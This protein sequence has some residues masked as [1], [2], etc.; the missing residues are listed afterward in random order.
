MPGLD[1]GDILMGFVDLAPVVLFLVAAIYLQ[2]DLYNKMSKGAFAVFAT[3]TIIVFIAGFLKAVHKI[4]LTFRVCNFEVLSKCFFPMQTVGFLLAGAGLLAVLLHEQGKGKAFV[5]V[6]PLIILGFAQNYDDVE[7]WSG[8]MLFVVLMCIGVL[9][10][11][12][13]LITFAIKLK[14][15]L[16]AIL[17]VV[18]FICTLGMG[19]LSTKDNMNDWIKEAVNTIGQLTLLVSAI[20]LRKNGLSNPEFKLSL[21]K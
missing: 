19:Y 20:L 7:V 3:G 9:L 11:D 13:A 8:T 2:R 16:I 18:S 10:F 15:P 1:F 12:G 5:T 21:R 17:L 6:I 4:L 14:K